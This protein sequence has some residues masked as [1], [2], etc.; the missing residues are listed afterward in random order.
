MPGGYP[1]DRH[2]L[3]ENE[4]GNLGIASADEAAICREPYS[5]ESHGLSD[6]LGQSP[7]R[8]VHR[9]L[10]RPA[11]GFGQRLIVSGVGC[12]TVDVAKLGVFEGIGGG[13]G[14]IPGAM[15]VPPLLDTAC[16]KASVVLQIPSQLDEYRILTD[17]RFVMA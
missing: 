8:Q 10:A 13:F 1:T 9:V 4:S 15:P 16:G 3:L 2:A 7:Q 12:Q 17:F 11:I 5:A 14:E 6:R